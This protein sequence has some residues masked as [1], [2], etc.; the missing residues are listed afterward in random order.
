M[1]HWK[2]AGHT[3]WWSDCFTYRHRH[4][5]SRWPKRQGSS[6]GIDRA[7]CEVCERLQ[8]VG[9]KLIRYLCWLYFLK[10]ARI[11]LYWVASRSQRRPVWSFLF[12]VVLVL[13]DV[14]L[15]LRMRSST[16]SRID[17]TMAFLMRSI[18]GRIWKYFC[19]FWNKL[20][21]W[22]SLK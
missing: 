6:N 15:T 21:F 2:F 13:F 20:H 18:L 7:F 19:F 12:S 17:L 14:L 4:S 16:D 10:I 22:I 11:N 1:L 5:S 8:V 9:T 3:A